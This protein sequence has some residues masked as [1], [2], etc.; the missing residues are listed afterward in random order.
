GQLETL[1]EDLRVERT[2]E[3]AVGR[4]DHDGGPADR[5]WL[6]RERVIDVG[7]RRDGRDRPRHGPREGRGRAHARHRLLDARSRDELHRLRD[8]LG[9]LSRTDLLLVDPELSA[10]CSA[11]HA[12]RATTLDDLLLVDVFGVRRGVLLVAGGAD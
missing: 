2:G 8:L 10:H 3:A 4:E 5:L 1:T 12:L 6:T 11:P 9:R 7:V